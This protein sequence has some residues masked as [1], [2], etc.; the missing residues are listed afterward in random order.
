[1]IKKRISVLQKLIKKNKIDAYIVP[2]T[3]SHQNEYLPPMWERR[4]WMSGFSGSAGD[5]VVTRKAAGLWTD[6]RYFLQAEQELKDSGIQLF[7]IGLPDTPTIQVWLKNKLKAGDKVGIDPQVISYSEAY[8][9]QNEFASWKIKLQTIDQNLVDQIWKDQPEFPTNPIKP[10]PLKFCGASVQEKLGVLRE[11]MKNEK[12]DVHI[13]ATLDTIAWLFNIRGSDVEY[14]P[15]VI[16]YAILSEKKAKLFTKKEKVTSALKSHLASQIKIYDYQEFPEQL[17]KLSKSKFKVWLD[18]NITSWWITKYL[19]KNCELFLKE[20]PIPRLKAIK[21]GVEIKGLKTA[22]VR[23]GVAMVKFLH[24]LEKTVPKGGVTEISASQRLEEF[25]SEQNLYQGPSFHSISAF[26]EHGAIVHYTSKPETNSDLKTKGIYLIDSGGQYLDGTTDITRTIA[27]GEPTKEQKDRFTRVLKG[28]IQLATARFP[29]GTAGNQ[30]D[31]IARKALWDMGLNYGHGT[32][33]G[34]GSYL[35]VHEGPHG[36]SFYRSIGVTL[37]PGMIISNEPGFYKS[38]A[39]GIRIENIILTVEDKQTSKDDIEFYKFE[40][41]T[42]CPIDV[43][44]IEKSLLSREEVQWL[45]AYH[46]EVRKK[47]S[48]H[49]K[50]E[51]LIWLKKATVAI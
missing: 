24:W 47:L 45:N 36:I 37:E 6:S 21:N 9:L 8:K 49:V 39:Y 14:N 51:P 23:D 15:V 48:L 10:H 7:K 12:A 41:L 44:L 22:L 50:G 1:M 27:F 40:T 3:D 43:N 28:H 18:P 16:S 25:R 20:S 13:L 42:L 17:K 4:R 46:A 31:T 19:K 30:L 5:L 34:I 11:R 26:G 38:G 2:S 35:N 33:H 29:K 32:G